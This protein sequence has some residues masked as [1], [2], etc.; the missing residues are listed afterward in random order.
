MR[1]LRQRAAGDRPVVL[2]CPGS[3]GRREC[4]PRSAGLMSAR[5]R[6]L[7]NGSLNEVDGVSPQTTVLLA[8]DATFEH[9]HAGQRFFAP[10]NAAAIHGAASA[11][12]SGAS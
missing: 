4:R 12:A 10:A 8:R 7:L 9:A 6:F 11:L 5:I 3:G 1:A 2:S